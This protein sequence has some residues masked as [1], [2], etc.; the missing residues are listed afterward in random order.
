MQLDNDNNEDNDDYDNNASSAINEYDEDLE[1]TGAPPD[2]EDAKSCKNCLLRSV[3]HM[4]DK[5]SLSEF[6]RFPDA[7]AEALA[8]FKHMELQALTFFEARLFVHARSYYKEDLLIC[9]KCL[10]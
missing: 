5:Y 6:V 3:V 1:G 8:M 4:K 9:T 7:C 2:E 10:R